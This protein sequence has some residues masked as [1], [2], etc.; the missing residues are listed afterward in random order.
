MI[1]TTEETLEALKRLNLIDTGRRLAFEKSNELAQGV[2]FG[3]ILYAGYISGLADLLELLTG[4][5][6]ETIK[7]ALA[8]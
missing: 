5:P 6:A 8:S 1:Q 7:K 3:S 4:E 2:E